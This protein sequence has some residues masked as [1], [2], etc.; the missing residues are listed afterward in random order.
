MWVN[1]GESSRKTWKHEICKLTDIPQ[2]ISVLKAPLAEG[3]D[4][5]FPLIVFGNGLLQ[6][7]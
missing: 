1:A 2:G 5:L 3:K 6:R 4:S 7:K